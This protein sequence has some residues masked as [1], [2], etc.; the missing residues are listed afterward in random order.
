MAKASQLSRLIAFK[1]VNPMDVTIPQGDEIP[2][3]LIPH[4]LMIHTDGTCH[5]R[6]QGHP[7]RAARRTFL[8]LAVRTG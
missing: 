5:T 6:Q 4:I 8:I 7:Y 2:A 3:A 1:V